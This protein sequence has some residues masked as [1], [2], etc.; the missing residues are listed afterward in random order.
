MLQFGLFTKAYNIGP[1]IN[2]CFQFCLDIEDFMFKIREAYKKK[3][4]DWDLIIISGRSRFI[5]EDSIPINKSI[6]EIIL[7]HYFPYNLS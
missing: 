1:L 5:S 7:V 3:K 6:L 4:E 2:Y